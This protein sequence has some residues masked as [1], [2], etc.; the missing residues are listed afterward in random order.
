M[1]SF[2]D[3]SGM[4][5]TF[6]PNFNVMNF[7]FVMQIIDVSMMGDSFTPSLPSP[8][9]RVSGFGATVSCILESSIIAVTYE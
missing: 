6:I 7:N 2:R 1:F 4:V 8:E 5:E 3:K 9:W